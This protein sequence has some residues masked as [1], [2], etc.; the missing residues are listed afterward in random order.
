M[1]WI[2]PFHMKNE[3]QAILLKSFRFGMEAVRATEV[4]TVATVVHNCQII[5]TF[6]W[7]CRELWITNS[8][9]NEINMHSMPFQRFFFLAS[10]CLWLI[11]QRQTNFKRRR[12]SENQINYLINKIKP[13]KWLFCRHYYGGDCNK[14][15][16]IQRITTVNMQF[17][18][19]QAN[20]NE[21]SMDLELFDCLN[22]WWFLQLS[23]SVEYKWYIFNFFSLLESITSHRCKKVLEHNESLHH[24]LIG[25]GDEQRAKCIRIFTNPF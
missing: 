24:K 1:N 4:A 5:N 8:K 19:T 13:E 25:N 18:Q 21:I 17:K 3:F 10:I 7:W 16:W 9:W 6:K 11:Q 2:F 20:W 22:W 14:N 23:P 15:Q 12:I